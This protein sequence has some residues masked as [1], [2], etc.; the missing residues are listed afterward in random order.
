MPRI[1]HVLSTLRRSG[2]EV[3]LA[4]AAPRFQAAG[5]EGHILST[6]ETPG[7]FAPAL[8]H[9]GY[10]IHHLPFARTA[11]YFAR[12][13]RLV[14]RLRPDVTHIHSEQASLAHAALGRRGVRTVHACF[15]F[16][17]ALRWRKAA[18]RW[19]CRSLF[20]VIH[21]A[22]SPSVRENERQRFLNDTV[23][24]PDWYDERRFQPPTDDQR[25]AAR[26]A[27][28]LA[29]DDV[30]VAS[31]GNHEPVKNYATGLRAFALAAA[32]SRLRFLHIGR[33]TDLAGGEALP[34]LAAALDLGAR[35]RFI[36]ETDEVARHLHAADAY[37][38]PSLREG[39]S[40]A[41]VEAMAC[42]LPQILAD[43]PGL[44]DFRATIP[45]V[46]Y[47]QPT[48]AGLAAALE[49]MAALDGPER[50]RRGAGI[51]AAARGRFSTAFGAGRY[52]AL[53][54]RRRR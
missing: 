20:G 16:T 13:H 48:V 9:A 39:F 44:A 8:E 43:V 2:A 46:V 40:I 21:I 27:L 23:L 24:C 22:P 6:G 30:V 25:L 50:R 37:L 42:G 1:L 12:F 5:W 49:G 32:D 47:A 51:A 11:G 10:I 45:D 28:G 35:A 7:A 53:Y 38:M 14:A 26:Q 3:M 17:G 19:L 31:V 34:Q 18:E 41:T 4:A 52:I 36:G 15:E 33:T 54:E 29:P